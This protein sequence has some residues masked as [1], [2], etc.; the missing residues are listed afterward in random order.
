MMVALVMIGLVGLF[1]ALRPG[2]TTSG[3][4]TPADEPQERAY[5][6]AIEN[7]AMSPVEV[8]V[9]EGDQVT[10]RLTSG[11]PLEVHLHGYDLE[12]EVLPG[13]ETV[14]SFEAEISGRFEIEDHETETALGALLVQPR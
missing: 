6:V 13:E 3:T 10:L 9:E 14:L 5:D 1:F 2:T 8:S 4:A 12:E 11:S 7:G